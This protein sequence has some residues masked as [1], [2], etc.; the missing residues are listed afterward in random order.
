MVFEGFSIFAV[1]M[2]GFKNHPKMSPKIIKNHEQNSQMLTLFFGCY[3]DSVF[4][5]I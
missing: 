1:S 4:A 3:F 5:Q 2:R